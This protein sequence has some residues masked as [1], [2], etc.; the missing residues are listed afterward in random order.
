MGISNM[1]GTVW[2]AACD[3]PGSFIKNVMSGRAF[4]SES[5]FP[6]G[7]LEKFNFCMQPIYS[8]SAYNLHSEQP[9]IVAG[10]WQLR[11]DRP[12]KPG[13]IA[14]HPG[15]KIRFPLRFGKHPFLVITYLKSYEGLGAV[16]LTM[17]NWR[18]KYGG[19]PIILQGIDDGY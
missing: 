14:E 12:G 16:K 13:W 4:L 10:D 1:L 6:I 11:E 2:K 8:Y 18:K 5:F 17:T 7:N 15:S 9:V 19:K 3:I